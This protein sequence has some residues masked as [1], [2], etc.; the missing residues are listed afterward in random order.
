MDRQPKQFKVDQVK[1]LSDTMGNAKAIVFVDYKGLGVQAQQGLKK[2]LS[3]T[4]RM[5]V[6]KNTLLR[7]ASEKANLPAESY[8]DQVLSGQTALV[9]SSEDE[10]T[11]VQI[12][13]KF[14]DQNESV[15]FKAGVIDGKFYD[16]LGLKKLAKLPSKEVL[17]AQV[18]G[19]V[20]A[21]MYG[22]VGTLQ[23]NLQKLVFILDSY[24]STKS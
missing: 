8:T 18:V 7:L 24:R 6:A 22:L 3:G 23:G 13:G 9:I 17:Y 2:D 20:A 12:L 15:K 1:S 21:P 5:L 10:V 19:G 14:A 16:E 4:A 11:S